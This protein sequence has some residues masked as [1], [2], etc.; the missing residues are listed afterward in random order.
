VVSQIASSDFA[1]QASK[2]A[3]VAGQGIQSGAKGAAQ[4]FNKF[5]EGSN[6][7]SDAP[8]SPDPDKRDFW[9]SFGQSGDGN[10]RTS[11]AGGSG[12]LG[13]GIL[14][15]TTSNPGPSG[16]G[17]GSRKKEDGWGDDW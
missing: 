7:T 12:S 8:T 15:K 4:Q 2:A 9:D 13:T 14:K 3:A 5:V 10:K 16:S 11:G 1:A 17:G 6:T